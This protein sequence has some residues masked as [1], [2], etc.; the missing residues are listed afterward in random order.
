MPLPDPS[1]EDL[2]SLGEPPSVIQHS[3]ELMIHCRLVQPQPVADI[4][5]DHVMHTAQETKEGLQSLHYVM[6]TCW[7]PAMI[8]KGQ[9][10]ALKSSSMGREEN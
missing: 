4:P 9:S 1:P 3:Y 2:P 6:P 5:V 10:T 8:T 7:C